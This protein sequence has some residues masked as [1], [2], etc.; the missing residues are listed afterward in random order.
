MLGDE[1][2]IRGHGR[3]VVAGRVRDVHPRQL[4][5]RRLVL[6]DGLEHALAHLRLVGRVGG[7]ELAALQDGV[8]HR[9]NVV[10]VHARAEERELDSAVSIPRRELLEVGDELRLAERRLETEPTSV[11]DALGDVPEELL[12]G[13]DPDRSEHLLAIGCR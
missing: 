5:D 11:S 8:D 12:D 4:A 7:Q 10:V 6:E 1:A 2:G 9:R 13:G 3:A